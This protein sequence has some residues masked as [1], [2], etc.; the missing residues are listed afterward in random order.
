MGGQVEAGG[1]P[2]GVRWKAG[3]EQRH[4]RRAGQGKNMESGIRFG[5]KE[6]SWDL[7]RTF[8]VSWTLLSG[9]KS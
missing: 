6:R 5:K 7:L 4:R 2:G 8:Y 1:V 3:A 9:C